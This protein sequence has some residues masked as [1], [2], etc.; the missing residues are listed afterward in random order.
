[1][2]ALLCNKQNYQKSC[3]THCYF[4]FLQR[5]DQTLFFVTQESPSKISKKHITLKPKDFLFSISGSAAQCKKL[6]IDFN[7]NILKAKSKL[8]SKSLIAVF[9]IVNANDV[10]Q[11]AAR[12]SDEVNALQAK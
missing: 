6:D 10:K 7:K 3:K 11:D 4:S 8:G 12:E 2:H 5:S 1:M 9:K